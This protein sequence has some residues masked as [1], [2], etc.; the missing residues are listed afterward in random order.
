M[1]NP[2]WPEEGDVL[3]LPIAPFLYILRDVTAQLQDAQ[4]GADLAAFAKDAQMRHVLAMARISGEK[5]K[6]LQSPSS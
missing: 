4:A 3:I 2:D 6:V 1:V 5:S